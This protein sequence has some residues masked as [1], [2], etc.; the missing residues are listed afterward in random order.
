MIT[1]LLIYVIAE[2]LL[3]LVVAR[4]NTALLMARGAHEAGAGHYPVMIALHVAWL[5]AIL[6]WVMFASPEV[7]TFFFVLYVVLQAFRFWV[8][9]SLGPYWT[10]RIITLPGAPLVKNGPYRFM[11]HPNY[12]LVVLEIILLPAVIGAWA[13]A[14]VF[15]VLNAAMLWVRIS[16]ENAALSERA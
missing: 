11:R 9:A 2:R 8:M 7:N 13:I 6:A 15:T 4:R 5:V 10:T 14:V 1:A 12:V 16:A 3:E